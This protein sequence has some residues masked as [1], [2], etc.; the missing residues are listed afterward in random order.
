[1]AHELLRYQPTEGGREGWLARIAE[2]IAIANKDPALGIA[3]GAGVPDPVAGPCAPG[4]AKLLQ[5][6]GRL[7]VRH[8]C[9]AESQAAK[10]SNTLQKTHASPSS[11]AEKIMTAPSMTSTRRARMSR[12]PRSS[13]T[14][15]GAS[16]SL[17]SG[18]MWS[19][20]RSLGRT[21]ARVTTGPPTRR[22]PPALH[23]RRPG[24]VWGSTRHGQLVPLGP[25]GCGANLAH[26]PFA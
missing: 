7:L 20:L 4:T 11:A 3:Q 18:A 24:H 10:S 1:M 17:A 2:L 25:Q 5:Q 12:F 9:R 26:E 15:P 16:L 13:S 6:I 19:G 23:H 22:V 14:T 21:S 8:L